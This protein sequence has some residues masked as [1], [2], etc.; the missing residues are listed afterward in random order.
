MSEPSEQPEAL[1]FDEAEATEF[2]KGVELASIS[3]E[4]A[5][6]LTATLNLAADRKYF[7]NRGAIQY[8][9]LLEQQK[10]DSL[11]WTLFAQLA[12][13]FV[14][15]REVDPVR[16]YQEYVRTLGRVGMRANGWERNSASGSEAGT[17]VDACVLRYL[18]P[19]LSPGAQGPLEKIIQSL[20]TEQNKKPLAIFNTSSSDSSSA[21][22][23]VSDGT[24]DRYLNLTIH[25]G[26]LDFK[27]NQQITNL[28]YWHWQNR[29]F[30]FYYSSDSLTLPKQLADAVRERLYERVASHVAANIDDI[31]LA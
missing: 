24:A 23:Q 6:A 4:R 30:T 11:Y 10:T 25:V 20:K 1:V 16:W 28:L 17:S 31:A 13:D 9:D 12:A 18:K 26:F 3:A 21:N 29:N 27:T 14:V 8:L 2:I 7:V 22:F 5:S 19:F 15:N